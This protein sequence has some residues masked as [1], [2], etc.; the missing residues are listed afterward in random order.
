[1]RIRR[2]VYALFATL[3]VLGGALTITAGAASA[4]VLGHNPGSGQ[5]QYGDPGQQYGNPGIQPNGGNNQCGDESRC[6]KEPVPVVY[7]S[8]PP[9]IKCPQGDILSG[10]ECVPCRPE[11]V[12]YTP[13][14]VIRC[15][16]D[17]VRDGN[18]CVPCKPVVTVYTPCR[19]GTVREADRCVPCKPTPVVYT[20]PPCK[21]KPVTMV[22]V[23][24]KP[25]PRNVCTSKDIRE[26][27]SL[28]KLQQRHHH[29]D[30][31]QQ[32]ELKYLFE[33]CGSG[34]G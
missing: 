29:L 28:L 23:A 14:P 9:V 1:V 3:A 15:A 17:Q 18:N 24:P 20:T 31:A 30:R 10:R 11:P 27:L 2:F 19:P 25:Q 8:P 7:N 5:Q 21:P 22:Y 33:L 16:A 13:P 4:S 34:R 6:V 26:E 32:R 12:V